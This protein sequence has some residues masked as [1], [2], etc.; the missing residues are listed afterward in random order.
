MPGK[1]KQGPC[2]H[3]GRPPYQVLP[4]T[5]SGGSSWGPPLGAGR[6]CLDSVPPRLACLLGKAE[7]QGWKLGATGTTIVMRLS[8]P[9]D[10]LALPFYIRWDLTPGKD[11][12][13]SWRFHG[14]LAANGQ[15]LGWHDIKVYLEDPSVIYPEPPEGE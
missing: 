15:R 10:Q 12:R 11:N 7:D 6:D 2:W 3:C 9:G 13:K 8:R 14:A 1:P 4:P 5:V